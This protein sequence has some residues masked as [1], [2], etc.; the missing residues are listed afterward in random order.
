MLAIMRST[1]QQWSLFG[2]KPQDGSS[3]SYNGGTILTSA[4]ERKYYV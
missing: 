3:F 2:Q 1:E 4:T